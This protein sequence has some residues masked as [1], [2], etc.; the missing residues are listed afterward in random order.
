MLHPRK[1]ELAQI[2][3]PINELKDRNYIIIS[4]DAAKTLTNVQCQTFG[5]DGTYFKIKT[6][7]KSIA[8][9]VLKKTCQEHFL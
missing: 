9:T 8:D 7:H 2:C 4:V 1:A 5:M 6:N 3:K